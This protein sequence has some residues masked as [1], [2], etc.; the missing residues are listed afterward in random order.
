MSESQPWWTQFVSAEQY[1]FIAAGFNRGLSANATLNAL[2]NAGL[3]VR[4]AN[5]LAAFRFAASQV[6]S[7]DVL[8]RT[9]PAFRPT[10][11]AFLPA[12]F[13]LPTQYQVWAK[14]PTGQ[15]LDGEPQYLYAVYGFDQQLTRDQ[16]DSGLLSVLQN[17]SDQ[18]AVPLDAGA[19]EYTRMRTSA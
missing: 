15:T 18:Y 12:P 2:S 7:G 6:G 8:A 9:V 11:S 3:G 10:Q 14:L 19:L 4:R 17:A 13:Q 16:I 5:G 1:Q